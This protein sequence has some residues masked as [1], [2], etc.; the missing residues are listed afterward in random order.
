MKIYMD[1]ILV[2]A[3]TNIPAFSRALDLMHA[4]LNHSDATE[5]FLLTPG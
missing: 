3:A 5:N 2:H 4:Q 1:L